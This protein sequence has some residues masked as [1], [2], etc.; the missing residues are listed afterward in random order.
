MCAVQ[1]HAPSGELYAG[2]GKCIYITQALPTINHLGQFGT[3]W[4]CDVNNPVPVVQIRIFTI[5]FQQL[6]KVH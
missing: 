3:S 1:I 4:V 5:I 6:L 2:L